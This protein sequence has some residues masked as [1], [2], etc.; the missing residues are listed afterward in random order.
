MTGP[1]T[2]LDLLER[3]QL[4]SAPQIADV[5]RD[6]EQSSRSLS[7][8]E[9]AQ[10]LVD[11][12]LLTAWQARQ[13]LAGETLFFLGKY[14]LLDELGHGGMGAVFK[15]EQAGIGRI[16]AVKVMAQKLVR[17]ETAVARF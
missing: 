4:L 2:F 6:V 11:R 7:P 12:R 9:L 14:K 13:L 10:R 5:R 1:T 17:D 8:P 3:S 16:V 15:A